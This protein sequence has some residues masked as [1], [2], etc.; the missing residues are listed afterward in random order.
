MHQ[1]AC[2]WLY[3]GFNWQ[4][5]GFSRSLGEF[6]AT[7]TFVGNIP[8]ETRTIPNCYLFADTAARWRR[9]RNAFSD[10]F[11]AGGFWRIDCQ[12]LYFT[13]LSAKT[14]SRPCFSADFQFQY[15]DF[16]LQ[17]RLQMQT[18]AWRYAGHQAAA[19]LRC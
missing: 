12:L 18:A 13:A 15:A 8:D 7:I 17:A 16:Q 11:T 1:L 19:S 10:P 3:Q 9:I 5:L 6:G 4:H 2:R 14:R